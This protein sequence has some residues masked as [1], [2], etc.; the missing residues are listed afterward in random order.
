MATSQGLKTKIAF[1]GSTKA[2]NEYF[3]SNQDCMDYLFKL[4]WP[5]GF[6]CES[7]EKTTDNPS[8]TARGLFLCKNC[9][10][11]ISITSG[12]LFHKTRKPLLTWFM[13]IWLMTDKT[14][15]I[16]AFSL[17][18][19]LEMGSYNTTWAWLHKLRSCMV[20]PEWDKLTGVIEMGV[21]H[22]QGGK[23]F[24]IHG[25]NTEQAIIVAIAAEVQSS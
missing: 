21:F 5:N 25:Q 19:K 3:K 14:Y 10:R 23:K 20:N 6:Y 22:I 13:A 4:R 11:Q 2:F 16:N 8:A 12:T 17:Q 7:C 18:K 9:N 15:K 1:P 24:K